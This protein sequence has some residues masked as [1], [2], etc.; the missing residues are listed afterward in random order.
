M[1]VWGLSR[2]AGREPGDISSGRESELGAAARESRVLLGEL[3]AGVEL[4]MSQV[5]LQKAR[6]RVRRHQAADDGALW[7]FQEVLRSSER[8]LYA[9]HSQ[10]LKL[11]KVQIATRL[12][13]D[14]AVEP[15]LRALE[16]RLGPA[17]GVFNCPEGPGR[18]PTRRFA[19]FRSAVGL[20]DNYLLIGDQ[21]LV[22]L[23][24]ASVDA[25]RE[26]LRAARCA[27]VAPEDLTRFP[28]IPA[29]PEAN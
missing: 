16:A 25:L 14:V 18:L 23:Y 3:V 12:E 17:T 26:S 21:I 7:M 29:R 9:V 6:P 2:R 19:W 13:S 8:A 5:A 4:G 24:V 20:V 1:V 11:E 10:T 22:T 15:R 28:A 27:P